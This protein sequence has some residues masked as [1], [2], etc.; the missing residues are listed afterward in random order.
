M[1]EKIYRVNNPDNEG[2]LT[3]GVIFLVTCCERICEVTNEKN[4]KTVCNDTKDIHI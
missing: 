3:T 2:Y 4:K 1:D